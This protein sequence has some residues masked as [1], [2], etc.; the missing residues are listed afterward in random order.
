MY[1][2]NKRIEIHAQFAQ[3]IFNS[4]EQ[5]VQQ[6]QVG[7][8]ILFQ[9]IFQTFVQNSGQVLGQQLLFHRIDQLMP[10]G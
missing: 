5:R 1:Y 9:Q 3:S 2:L 8:T 7:Q 6:R 10:E 4:A